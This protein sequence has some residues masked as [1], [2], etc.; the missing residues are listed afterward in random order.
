MQ[1]ETSMLTK[2]T[3]LQ[4]CCLLHARFVFAVFRFVVFVVK[5]LF[6]SYCFVLC[7]VVPCAYRRSRQI[8][9]AKQPNAKLRSNALDDL[10]GADHC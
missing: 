4:V 3:H 8:Y 5:L 1:R 10:V 7:C 6:S 9:N 2:R